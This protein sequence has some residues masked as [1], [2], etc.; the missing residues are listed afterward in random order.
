[1]RII[2]DNCWA[3]DAYDGKGTAIHAARLEDP[4][5]G[6]VLDVY[7]TQ[8]GVQVYTGNWLEGSPKGKSGNEYHD[9]DAVAIECQAFPDSPNKPQFPATILRPGEKYDQSII[10]RFSAK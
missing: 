6:R 7:T 10:F 3:L 9:Y 4:E 2:Y 8:P 5:S 1:M